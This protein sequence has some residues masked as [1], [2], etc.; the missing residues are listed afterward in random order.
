MHE[1]YRLLR[2]QLAPLRRRSSPARVHDSRIAARQLRSTLSALAP[3]LPGRARRALRHELK[4]LSDHLGAARDAR[5][6]T[7][8][9]LPLLQR[10]PVT[11]RRQQTLVLLRAASRQASA[12]AHRWLNA[13]A[14]DQCLRRM[15]RAAKTLTRAAQPSPNAKALL[16]EALLDR[17]SRLRH[18]PKNTPLAPDDIHRLRLMTKKC[19]YLLAIYPPTHH[20]STREWLKQLQ[21]CLGDLHDLQQARGWLQQQHGLRP[22]DRV[23]RIRLGARTARLTTQL[24]ALLR[25]QPSLLL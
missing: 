3:A 12:R 18:A 11:D 20:A 24:R 9:L 2:A 1:Q 6:R 4:T 23:L 17:W 16:R 21:G 13:A 25:T 15:D 19:R 10:H 7:D 8:L 14:F 5:V 22:P